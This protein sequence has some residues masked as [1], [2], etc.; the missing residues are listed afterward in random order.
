[1]R[2]R[3]NNAENSSTVKAGRSSSSLGC[4]TVI[5][6]YIWKPIRSNGSQ[7]DW[8]ADKYVTKCYFRLLQNALTSEETTTRVVKRLTLP[9]PV[10]KVF[11]KSILL[12]QFS[13][14]KHKSRKWVSY[15][16]AAHFPAQS[17]FAMKQCGLDSALRAKFN[18][19][20]HSKKHSKSVINSSNIQIFNFLQHGL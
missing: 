17:C 14:H 18:T 15:D 3:Q 5:W 12:W 2:Q 9:S 4:W 19:N 13:N 8:Q 6:K 1:M 7:T 10:I 16:W 11:K 20:A